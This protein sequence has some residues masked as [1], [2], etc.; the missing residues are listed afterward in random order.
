MFSKSL[1]KQS[2]KA[3]GA[4]WAIITFA[5]CFMLACV[6][7]IAGGGNL[8]EAKTAIA[9]TIIQGELTSQMQQRAVNYYMISNE[10]LGHFDE[11]FKAELVKA[12]LGQEAADAYA[13]AYRA[14]L[15]AGKSEAEA[16][17]DGQAAASRAASSVA[18]AASVKELSDYAAVVAEEK[19]YAADSVEAKEIQGAIFTVLNP[20]VG[21][22]VYMFDEFYAKQGEAAPRYE[23]TDILTTSAKERAAYRSDYAAKNSAVF[24]AGNMIEESNVQ[25]VVDALASFGVTKEKYREFGF[26]DYAQIKDIA[27]SALIDF[28]ANLA[29]RLENI[30]DG[31]TEES[32]VAELT[33]DITQSLLASLPSEVGDALEEIGQMDMYGTLVGSIFFKMAGLLLPIIYLI[34]TAN[35]LIAGQVDSGSMAYILSSSVKRRAVTFTQGVFLVGSLFLMFC[36]TGVTSIVCLAVVDVETSLTYAKLLLI[37]L[38]AFLVMFAM[39]GICF[40]ASCWF[41]RSKNSMAL[42]GGLTMFFLVA[43]MLGLFGSPVLPSIVRMKALNNFNYVSIIS[44]F[45]VVSILEGTTAFL[46]KLGILAAVGIVCYIVGSR[47][48][49]RKDLPL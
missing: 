47:K 36:C 40:L 44:L 17:A 4:M 39:S 20:M 8:A 37:N 2:C 11:T 35:S 29:Y 15:E 3:N 23:L 12:A 7:L 45:D 28:R 22:D 18:Y 21:A 26:D 25:L 32:I 42:G 14:S 27:V 9:D 13:A 6:M 10:A 31:E 41:N 33:K 5:T 1:F 16:K 49:A 24:L 38:G 48:F 43:T 30:R 19:G 46:W 34:M